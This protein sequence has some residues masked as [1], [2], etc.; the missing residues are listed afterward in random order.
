MTGRNVFEN[1]SKIAD[2]DVEVLG[3]G[4][5]IPLPELKE[6]Y[7]YTITDLPSGRKAVIVTGNGE[8]EEPIT[9]ENADGRVTYK[10]LRGNDEERTCWCGPFQGCATCGRYQGDGL[11]DPESRTLRHKD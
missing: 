2:E 6:G 3:N 10:D 4:P 9:P 8:V 5:H 7:E 11:N 1:N